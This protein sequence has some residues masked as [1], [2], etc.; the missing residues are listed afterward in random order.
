CQSPDFI[1]DGAPFVEPSFL[2]AVRLGCRLMA[3]GERMSGGAVLRRSSEEASMRWRAVDAVVL[4]ALTLACASQPPV[5]L[6]D[7]RVPVEPLLAKLKASG[8]E[9]GRVLHP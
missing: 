5:P 9:A 8:R 7:S 6:F 4:C 2:P 3:N 1:S